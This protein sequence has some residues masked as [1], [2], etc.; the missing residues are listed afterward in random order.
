MKNK[1]KTKTINIQYQNRYP[2]SDKFDS[3][4]EINDTGN[5][6]IFFH[7]NIKAS[8]VSTSSILYSTTITLNKM[9]ARIDRQDDTIILLDN[10][11]AKLHKEPYGLLSRRP[12]TTI[13]TKGVITK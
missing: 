8:S 10:N 5:I 6:A 13:W 4:V 12:A 11:L 3:L 1:T 2:H 7:G 9:P